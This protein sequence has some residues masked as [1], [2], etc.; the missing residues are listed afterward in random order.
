MHAEFFLEKMKPQYEEGGGRMM[1]GN[2]TD[3][4]KF[5]LPLINSSVLDFGFQLDLHRYRSVFD[6]KYN[7]FRNG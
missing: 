1:L 6:H 7:Q 5:K 3:G 2:D 4:W